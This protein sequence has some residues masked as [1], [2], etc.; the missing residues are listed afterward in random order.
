MVTND[1]L[2]ALV[3]PWAEQAHPEK[4]AATLAQ[5]ATPVRF[6]AFL[7]RLLELR[8]E[9]E[10]DW[11]LSVP[12]TVLDETALVRT[13]RRRSSGQRL[14]FAGRRAA[15]RGLPWRYL[16][17]GAEDFELLTGAISALDL[18]MV[19]RGG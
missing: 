3:G 17:L 6:R 10:P 7:L 1:E 4:W 14:V 9:A 18:E 12:T 5:V 13:L 15:V 16:A 8:A 11:I 19:D 2:R